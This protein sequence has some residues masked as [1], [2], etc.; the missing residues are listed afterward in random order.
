V[1]AFRPISLAMKPVTP[2]VA[3]NERTNSQ[4]KTKSW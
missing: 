2:L 3:S 4:E 1:F